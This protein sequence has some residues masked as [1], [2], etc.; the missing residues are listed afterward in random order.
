M[1]IGE[2]YE[3]KNGDFLYEKYDYETADGEENKNPFFK[4]TSSSSVRIIRDEN[5]FIPYD[6]LDTNVYGLVK[7]YYELSDYSG[8]NGN[9]EVVFVDWYAKPDAV[10][11]LSSIKPGATDVKFIKLIDDKEGA[12]YAKSTDKT[13]DAY[14]ESVKA[15]QTAYQDKIDKAIEESEEGKLYAGGDKKFYLPA[16]GTEFFDD[17]FYATD[18]KYTIYYKAGSNSSNTAALEYNKL[19]IDLNEADVTYKFTIFIT[20]GFGNP[21]RY[22]VSKDGGETV[23]WEE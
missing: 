6:L 13:E 3:N 23:E 14:K 17:Y 11:S 7:I 15:F 10:V 18:Y 5:S 19:A 9:K 16:L 20:D 4:I 22:P 1:F 12:T 8:T 2:Q 21:M